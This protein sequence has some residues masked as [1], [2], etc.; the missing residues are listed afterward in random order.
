MSI[1]S[2]LRSAIFELGEGRRHVGLLHE[3]V[4]QRHVI[5]ALAEMATCARALGGDVGHVAVPHGEQ[6]DPLV[7]HLVVLQVVQQRVGRVARRRR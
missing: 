1:I 3:A 4:A 6:N 7:Q 2:A 5:H